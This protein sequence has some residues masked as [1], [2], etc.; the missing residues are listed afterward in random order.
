MKHGVPL[1]SVSDVCWTLRGARE[2]KEG[3]RGG[4]EGRGGEGRG[5]E[6]RGGGYVE[7]SRTVCPAWPPTSKLGMNTPEIMVPP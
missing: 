4:D 6:G 7:G 5:G 2:A 1:S 3:M